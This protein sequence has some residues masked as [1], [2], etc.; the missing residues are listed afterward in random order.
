[1]GSIPTLSTVMVNELGLQSITYQFDTHWVPRISGLVLQLSFVKF[2]PGNTR[3]P[4]PARRPNLVN[5]KERTC[6]E[7]IWFNGISTLDSYSMLNSER[8]C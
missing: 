2:V 6:C 4:I 5:K 1:M 3:H 8:T 7:A